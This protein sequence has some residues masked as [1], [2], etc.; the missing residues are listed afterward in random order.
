MHTKRISSSSSY[1]GYL[2][3]SSPDKLKKAID[4]NIGLYRTILGGHDIDWHTTADIAY[5][6]RQV[7]Q[8][9][10]NIVTRTPDWQPD[11]TFTT[12]D[13]SYCA[14]DWSTWSVKDSFR[15]LDLTHYGFKRLFEAHWIY[16]TID[17][18]DPLPSTGAHHQIVRTEADLSRWIAAWGIG[19]TISGPIF[20]NELLHDP[21]ITFIA[22]F[23]EEGNVRSGCIINRTDDVLGISNFFGTDNEETEMW[24]SMIQFVSENVLCGDIVGYESRETLAKLDR[25]GFEPIGDLTVWLKQRS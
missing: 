18:F 14:Q 17:E 3:I 16:L 15:V 4:N 1:P 21:D 23:N 9:Y 6:L 20:C 24:S 12:I 2:V 13:S 25:I 7:P 11:N 19:E 10:S 8:L 5:S 22:G